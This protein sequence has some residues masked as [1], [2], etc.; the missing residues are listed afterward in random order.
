MDPI[1]YPKFFNVY[2]I[3]DSCIIVSYSSRPACAIR[4][5]VLI[6]E[7]SLTVYPSY[8]YGHVTWHCSGVIVIPI[9]L[10]KDVL[11]FTVR[12]PVP[13]TP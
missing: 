12:T 1:Y 10:P 2:L 3:P 6:Q 9:Y 5:G 13:L 11:I 7:I 4:G 8:G